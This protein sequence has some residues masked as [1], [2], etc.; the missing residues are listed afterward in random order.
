M[1]KDKEKPC[2]HMQAFKMAIASLEETMHD[3]GQA[4]T[5]KRPYLC[6]AV[7]LTEPTEVPVLMCFAIGKPKD[8][9]IFQV[10]VDDVKKIIDGAMMGLYGNHTVSR[11]LKDGV[12]QIYIG[13]DGPEGK[14]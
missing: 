13:E 9:E 2:K 4:I 7:C 6:C 10:L 12:E 3:I 11:Y 5:E 1:E 8:A 14:G